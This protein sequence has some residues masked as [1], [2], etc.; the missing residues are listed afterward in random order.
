MPTLERN[1]VIG[2]VGLIGWRSSGCRCAFH[3]RFVS[4]RAAADKLHVGRMYLESVPR[5]AVAIGPFF[6]A[7]PALNVNRPALRQVLR[8]SFCLASPQRYAKPRRLV[9]HLAGLILAPF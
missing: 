1:V 8:S 7:Q 3:W 5:L 6:N 4:T 2:K 9:L